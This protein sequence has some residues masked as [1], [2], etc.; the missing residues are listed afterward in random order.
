[1][2]LS[3]RLTARSSLTS[4]TARASVILSAIALATMA[5]V[6][7]AVEEPTRTPCAPAAPDWLRRVVRGRLKVALSHQSGVKVFVAEVPRDDADPKATEVVWAEIRGNRRATLEI[8]E[9]RADTDVTAAFDRISDP[10]DLV[11]INGSFWGYANDNR[12]RIPLGLVVS[13]G[14]KVV[15]RIGWT[16]GGVVY[17]TRS[18][19]R[20]V[21]VREPLPATGVISALQSKPIVVAEGAVDIRNETLPRER[22]NRTAIGVRR[23]GR[24]EFIVVAGVFA[25]DDQGM[26]LCEFAQFLVIP[27]ARRGPAV[28]EAL[29]MDGGPGA[30]LALPGAREGRL[31]HFGA[32]AAAYVPNVLRVRTTAAR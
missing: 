20:V 26:T 16:S 2:Q 18:V 19:L 7:G 27:R 12:T 1:M 10:A 6:A 5:A 9:V 8:T 25:E 14:K 22:N 29:S 24:R 23:D 30:H 3:M 21:G 4:G 13:N 28:T 17:A 31:R 32:A 11:L 15:D